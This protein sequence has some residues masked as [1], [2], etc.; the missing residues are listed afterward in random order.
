M[1]AE[2]RENKNGRWV[3]GDFLPYKMCARL[4]DTVGPF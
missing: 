2:M 4:L 1:V 3:R